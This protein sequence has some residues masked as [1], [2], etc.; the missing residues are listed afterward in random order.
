ML[1]YANSSACHTTPKLYLLSAKCHFVITL[2]HW[3]F[4]VVPHRASRSYWAKLYFNWM[5]CS[6]TIFTWSS[7]CQL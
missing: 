7:W 3:E 1:C 5:Q 6:K 2:V 4:F